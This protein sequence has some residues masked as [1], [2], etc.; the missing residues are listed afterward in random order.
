[1][2]RMVPSG[3]YTLTNKKEGSS[4]RASSRWALSATESRWAQ[5]RLSMRRFAIEVR[6]FS[7]EVKLCSTI[8]ENVRA[9]S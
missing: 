2:A 3:S 8:A 6:R 5:A 1:M 9:R 7:A 4:L